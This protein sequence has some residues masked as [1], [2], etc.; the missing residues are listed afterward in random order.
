[1]DEKIFDMFV[2]SCLEQLSGIESAVL[3]LEKAA[4]QESRAKVEAVFRAAH[5]IKGDA[6]AMGAAPLAELCH[7]VESVLAQVRDGS[8]PVDV[9]LG[10]ELL[11]AFDVV[12]SM[13]RRVRELLEDAGEATAEAA[14]EVARLTALAAS[15]ATPEPSAAAEDAPGQDAAGPGPEAAPPA[16]EGS[17][18]RRLRDESLERIESITIPAGELDILVDRVGELGIVQARLE[19]LARRLGDRDFMTVAE[20]TGR[21]C[22]LLRDQA[23]GLR[24]LPLQVSFLKYRRLVR[25]ACAALGKEAALVL[26]GENTELDKTLIERLNTP[27]LHLLRNA[28]DHGIET[29]EKRRAAGKP[30]CGRISLSARQ[31]GN[32]VVIEVTDDGAGIDADALWE[33]AVARGLADPGRSLSRQEKLSLIFVPGLSTASGVGELS[34]RGVGMDA[35]REGIESLRGDIGVDSEPG[36]GTVFTIRLP[37]SL[38]IIDCLE[39]RAGGQAFFFHLDYVEECLEV[40][41]RQAADATRR[42]LDLRGKPTPMLCLAEFF[43]LAGAP[44]DLDLPAHAVVVRAAGERFCILVDEVLGQKQ[45]VLKH[46]GPALGHVAG[47]LGGTVTEEGFMALVL[48][49]PGLAQAALA[50]PAGEKRRPGA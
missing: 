50:S 46:L 7:A 5:T 10:G 12:R 26:D 37:V 28:V 34:G 17:R 23:L 18:P 36:R 44:C 43:A 15:P 48:D 32:E 42:V 27:I 16:W 31:D 30:V 22:A 2:E 45:A 20:E 4:P 11:R 35:A 41:R 8:R 6:A 25:D 33:H 1:M 13:V 3:D 49:V 40:P 38:A 9:A 19:S 29:P 14:G 39:V 47:I 24:M 21:L